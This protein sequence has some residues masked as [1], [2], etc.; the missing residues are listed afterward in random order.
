MK[1]KY[2]HNQDGITSIFITYL[3]EEFLV[4]IST[5]HFDKVNSY[6]NWRMWWDHGSRTYY[7]AATSHKKNVYLHR[8][9][10][11]CGSGFEPHHRDGNGLNNVD[12]NL[13]VLTKR[14]HAALTRKKNRE[15][16]TGDPS[17]GVDMKWLTKS[18]NTKDGRR[19]FNLKING[20]QFFTFCDDI[21]GHLKKAIAVEIVRNNASDEQIYSLFYR[22]GYKPEDYGKKIAKSISFVRRFTRIPNPTVA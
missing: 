16:F 4:T 21:D 14:E 18:I 6:R 8:V 15:P 3:D 13:K 20:L 11:D 2:F 1:N 7:V 17:L 22:L 12:G 9:V 10:T 5:R 19:Y